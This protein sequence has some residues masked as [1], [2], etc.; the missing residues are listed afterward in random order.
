MPFVSLNI[1]LIT[2]MSEIRK[3]KGERMDKWN[4]DDGGC[5]KQFE[6]SMLWRWR[7]SPEFVHGGF[8]V[9]GHWQ[10]QQHEEG[11]R[12]EGEKTSGLG[13]EKVRGVNEWLKAKPTGSKFARMH[14]VVTELT[15]AVYSSLD[16]ISPYIR[17]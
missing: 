12:R 7:W 9:I 8:L 11:E 15:V 14:C 2:E 1:F 3:A 4:K 6:H 10:G 13:E 5:V 17:A 16:F